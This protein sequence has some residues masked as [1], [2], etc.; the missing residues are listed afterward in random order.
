MNKIINKKAEVSDTTIWI[1]LGLFLMGI[2]LFIV[3]GKLDLFN[4]ML[5][6]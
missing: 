1:I 3:I 6:K 4:T 2:S 5:G